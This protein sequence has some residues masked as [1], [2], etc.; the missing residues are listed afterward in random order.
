VR[1]LR[2]LLNPYVLVCRL[3]GLEIHEAQPEWCLGY[4]VETE[5]DGLT[6]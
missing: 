4:H 2:R 6:K 5:K 1:R 3:C